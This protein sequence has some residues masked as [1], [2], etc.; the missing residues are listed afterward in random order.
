LCTAP[1]YCFGGGVD[2]ADIRAHGNTAELVGETIAAD[3][4]LELE[5]ATVMSRLPEDD[6]D[7]WYIV[8]FT[9]PNCAPC[10][11]LV[12]DF[13]KN[14]ALKELAD[15]SHFQVYDLSRKSQEYKFDRFDVESYPTLCVLPPP[16]SKRYPYC[17]VVRQEGY[18]GNAGA[19][20]EKILECVGGYCDAIDRLPGTDATEGVEF[21][22]R[23]R[24]RPTPDCPDCEPA[25]EPDTPDR[26]RLLNPDRERRI[27]TLDELAERRKVARGGFF[28]GILTAAGKLVGGFIGL[29]IVLLMCIVLLGCGLVLL[30][31]F[32]N[33]FFRGWLPSLLGWALSFGGK[34]DAT[35]D[36]VDTIPEVVET[37]VSGIDAI[38]DAL[39]RKEERDKEN[40]TQ[41]AEL[42]A[43]IR[44]EIRRRD[45]EA[46]QLKDAT[47]ALE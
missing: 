31:V 9:E 42:K 34:K 26:R 27:P 3:G 35:P 47:K 24:N 8:V 10:K 16:N 33:K 22:G 45:E 44:E 19:L 17:Y 15:S 40:A 43:A 38:L 36:R 46:E 39:R 11:R 18:D 32:I 7:K 41:D 23:W 37:A 2:E 30:Y 14:D 4:P 25:P 21:R 13:A 28:A 1:V 5:T 29:V 6:S 20:A 12:A